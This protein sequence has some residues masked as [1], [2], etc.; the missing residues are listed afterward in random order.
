[1]NIEKIIQEDRQAKLTVEYTPEEFNGFKHRA[2]KR[3]AKRAKIPGFRPGKAPFQVIVNHYGEEV[4]VQEAIDLLIDTDYPEILNQA[5]IEPSGSGNLETL[6]SLDPPKFILMVPLKP[7]IELGDYREIRKDYAPEAFNTSDVD[8]YIMSLRRNSATIVPA[9][10]PAEVGDLVYFNLSGEFLNPGEDDDASITD[11]TPQQAVVS[12]EDEIPDREWPYPGFS[13]QLLGVN[14]NDTKEIQ[15][16]YPDDYEDEEY[17]GKTA[18]FTVEVQS[19][20]VLELP[21]LDE[22]FVQSLGEFESPE[23]FREKLE[24]QMLEKHESDYE[25]NYINDLLTEII[26]KANLNYPPQMLEHEQEHI[27]ADIKSRLEDQN[28]D[29]ETYLKLRDSDED[30]FIEEEIVPT[31]QQR[32]ERSLVVDALIE[33][34]GLKLDKELLN[35]QVSNVLNEIIRSGRIEE[36]QKQ[37]GQDDFSRMVSMEGVSR[38][39][40]VLLKERLKL[41]GTG[42]PIPEDDETKEDASIGDVEVKTD[43]SEAVADLSLASTEKQQDETVEMVESG[44]DGSLKEAL[45]EDD[46]STADEAEQPGSDDELQQKADTEAQD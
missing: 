14:E 24:A 9:D 46:P 26:E 13:R 39:M 18:I 8:D 3:L 6:E 44:A 16:T 7:E 25:Q 38:T 27:L 28:M 32:L 5:E 36:V 41:I 17:Q 37:M 42:Q 34:E 19:V 30:A 23:D 29:F 35:E 22:N 15:Y 21:E 31:A 11:K 40:D 45:T 10:H 33:T 2:A 1:M 12:A 20:K 4:I 43:I